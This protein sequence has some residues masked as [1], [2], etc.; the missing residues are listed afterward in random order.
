M[1]YNAHT[2][3]KPQVIADT[4]TKFLTE[5][6]DVLNLFTRETPDKWFGAADETVT[7]R[8]PGTLPVRTYGWKNDRSQPIRTDEYHEKTVDVKINATDYYNA[9]KLRDEDLAFDFGGSF[10]KLTNAQTDIIA[11]KMNWEAVHQILNLKFEY[12][13]AVDISAKNIKEQADIGRDVFYNAFVD[14]DA[15]LTKLRAPVEN[16]VAL[17]GANVAADI[18]KSQKLTKVVGD[19]TPGAFASQVIG[20]YA[21]FSIVKHP[22]V[23]ADDALLVSKSGLAFWNYAPAVP[24]GAVTGATASVDGISMRWIQD[25]DTAYMLDRS[26]WNTWAGFRSVTDHLVQ[27]NADETQ[28]I[29]GDEQYFLRGIKL[30]FNDSGQGGWEPGDGKADIADRAGASP[31]SELAKVFN[32]LPFAGELPVGQNF[33]NVLD[34]AIAAKDAQIADLAARLEALEGAS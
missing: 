3:V 29:I 19:N 31:D 13:Q 20:T 25:Y 34:T 14:A 7:M 32:G 6:T 12:C 27:K 18:A 30:T 22:D 23:G 2:V 9:T 4:G 33:P 1:A 15:A 16:R 11:K 5:K 26:V 28:E 10:G 17:V 8:V 24:R 21:G